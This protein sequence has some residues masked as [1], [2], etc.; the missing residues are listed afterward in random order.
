VADTERKL[1]S[2]A[3]RVKAGRDDVDE[4]VA[5]LADKVRQLEKQLGQAQSQAAAK[6]GG[7][8]ASQA[9]EIG[10]VKVLS[11]KL[12]GADSKVLRDTLDQL[13]SKLGSAVI[14]LGAATG[15]K[16]SV[17]A[18][19]TKDQTEKVKAG[20]LVNFVAQQVGGKGGGRPDMAQAGGT[21]PQNLDA[22]LASVPDWVKGKL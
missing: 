8:L 4:K 9:V 1:L 3:E 22:A 7:E 21:Q 13:K 6:Q 15:D 19:V 18:G 20:D 2:V 10:G 5:Q 17:I 16:V 14:V 11:A 12:D